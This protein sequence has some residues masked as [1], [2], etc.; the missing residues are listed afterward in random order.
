[1]SSN[2]DKNPFASLCSLVLMTS[3]GWTTR[4][5][6]VPAVNPAAVSM[7]DDGRLLFIGLASI[8]G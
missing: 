6:T 2:C 4:V 1:M 5:E 7:K 8:G 3:K